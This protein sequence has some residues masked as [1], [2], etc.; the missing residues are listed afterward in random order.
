[1]RNDSGIVFV[2]GRPY[3]ICVMTAFLSNERAGEEAISK[4]SLD[5][6]RMFDRLS[7]ATEYG[8]VVSPGNGTREFGVER[9]L[10]SAA[11]DLRWCRA[12][13]PARCSGPRDEIANVGASVLARAAV[14]DEAPRSENQPTPT[15]PQP[16]QGR[17]IMAQDE[18]PGYDQKKIPAPHSRP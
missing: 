8:R 11:L 16:R 2:E 7:R 13:A 18:S 12:G 1:M 5:A 9:K 17:P 10:L 6:W 3:V 15:K 14:A 4:V